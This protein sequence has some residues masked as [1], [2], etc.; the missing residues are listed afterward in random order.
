MVGQEA[1]D[2]GIIRN[3]C[4]R[5][6]VEYRNAHRRNV[7]QRLQVCSRAK[8]LLMYAGVGY[9]CSRL[10]GQHHNGFFIFL[11]K[12]LV[13]FFFRK[14]DVADVPSPLAYLHAQKGLHRR[15]VFRKANGFWMTCY[16]RQPQRIFDFIEVAEESLTG[17]GGLQRLALFGSHAGSKY[18]PHATV[19]IIGQKHSVTG[20]GQRAGAPYDFL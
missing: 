17:G 18:V 3:H 15:V 2:F 8:F 7:Y 1:F 4:A 10:G 20:T 13:S 6:G 5:L 12:F 14:E 19:L 9:G 16:I 11:G